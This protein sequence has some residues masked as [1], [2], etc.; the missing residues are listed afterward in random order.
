M[1]VRLLS[2]TILLLGLL[3][4][5]C[6]LPS[7]P[8]GPENAFVALEF[9][10]SNG[11]IT[12]EYMTDSIGKKFTI[13]LIHNLTQ[14]IDSSVL[15]ITKGTNFDEVFSVRSFK[16]QVDTT[17]YPAL[18]S[19]TGIYAVSFTG[20]IEEKTTVLSGKIAIVGQPLTTQNQ[21]PLLDVPKEI[22]TGAGQELVIPV[23]ATDPDM[24]Q[25]VTIT[26]TG[27]PESATFNANLFTWTPAL[28]DTGSVTVKFTATDNGSP[29]L[30]VTDSCVIVV[31]A[32]AV[33]R[34]PQWKME[35][36]QLSTQPEVPFSLDVSSY[37]IDA[38]NDNLTFS[39]LAQ[40]PAIGTITGNLYQCTP[41]VT[42]IGLHSIKIV[43]SD[44]SGLSDTLSLE[45]TVKATGD[46]V[47]PDTAPPVITFK[48]PSKDTVISVDSF[49]VKVTCVDDSGSSVLGYCDGIAFTM[50]KV[51]SVPNLWNGM[52]RG[53]KAGTSSTIKITATDSSAAKNMDSAFVQIQWSKK[54]TFALTINADNGSVTKSPDAL[55]YD[56]GTVVTLTPVPSNN[57]HFS[58]WSGDLT[59]ST[60]PAKVTMNSVKTIT[61]GFEV[62]PPS[63]FALTVVA[64]NGT[65]KKNPDLMM[66]DS[67]SAVGLKAT[68]ANGYHF[69]KWT[70]DATGATDSIAV[71]MTTA[72]SLTA[73]FELNS[74]QLTLAA[75]TGGSI[76]VPTS[77]PAT[78]NHGVAT[79]I[80][81]VAIEG[82]NFSGWTAN[83]TATVTDPTSP[84][85]TVTLTGDATVTANFTQKSYSLKVSAGTG[86]T[87]TAPTSSPVTLDHGAKTTITAVADEGYSFS[88]WT[89]SGPATVANQTS[90]ST[91]V[92]LTG[93]ATVTAK[94]NQK[95][96]S[97]KVSAGT[98]GTITAPASSPVTVNHGVATTITAAANTGYTFA[99]WTVTGSATVKST[100]TAS[101]TMTL[102]GDATVNANFNPNLVI[103]T[104]VKVTSP[105][106]SGTT[107]TLTADASLVGTLHWYSGAC[108]TGAVGTGTS[109]TTSALT[110]N[111]TFYVRAE[112]GTSYGPCASV[113]VTVS[114]QSV[115][116]TS[117]N[118]TNANPCPGTKVKL[119]VSGGSLGSGASW[120]WYTNS[121]CTQV[122]SGTALQEDGSQF[123][124][125]TPAITTTYYV[126]AEGS[127]NKTT[128]VSRTITVQDE[129]EPATDIYADKGSSFCYGDSITL[130][131]IEGSLGSNATWK[132]YTN[133]GCT[134]PAP[135]RILDSDGSRIKV[136]PKSTTTYYVRAEGG[137]NP[138][139]TKNIKLTNL[140]PTITKQPVS[141][142]SSCQKPM[143]QFSVEAIGSSAND[144][145]SYQWVKDNTVLHDAAGMMGGVTTPT[146]QF[147]DV[148][149]F[150][151]KYYCTISNSNCSISS[152]EVE[153]I[154]LEN[155]PCP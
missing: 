5:V 14:Y 19:D 12:K 123:E 15:R 9:K 113:N 35:L 8:P 94:F 38:D 39:L 150:A 17:N 57:Y 56:S 42:D 144:V 100:S 142:S 108:G 91:T 143:I 55:S 155:P 1:W 81:A 125:T 95:S 154:W 98:G 11:A 29:A 101:T 20:Y 111:T 18:L 86:G 27:K 105:V 16:N 30:S 129:S 90:A 62:N 71:Q 84:T 127:C 80:T 109:V 130:S 132:W 67:G 114:T 74:Y 110:S 66:Y 63:T 48:S 45:L 64:A 99:G 78:V 58:S 103:P 44:P 137:C 41:A 32:T 52:V 50:N 118:A 51:P 43:A 10:N 128:A 49:E 31:S 112:L 6:K 97:L 60:N 13:I 131:V 75:E 65:V 69:V 107:A 121:E 3:L 93:N 140:A 40:P 4:L 147:F 148:E 47:K 68:A 21:K 151:G 2:V 89:V 106:C 117:I 146:I 120:K 79:P 149:D 96:Y 92:T 83:E 85:T 73:N 26:V 25:Q 72:K 139:T 24:N 102:T 153:F 133:S 87:I 70:G 122:A 59:G 135:G 104:N 116:A 23:S 28:E 22:K 145:L 124:I 141:V 76:S 126:L 88:S 82:Y 61:A 53:L 134:T 54:A 46:T 36:I 119:S 138:T 34:A 115:A 37:C 7:P 136:G 33:N 152:D 77:S